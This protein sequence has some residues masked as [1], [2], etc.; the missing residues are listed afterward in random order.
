MN[1]I[2]ISIASY[3]DR[4]CPNTLI[5]L[6]ENAKNPENIIVGICQQNDSKKD[7][8][9][10][11]PKEH[12]LYSIIYKNIRKISIPHHLAKGPTYARF[13]CSTLHKDEDF[14]MQIDSHTYFIPNWDSILLEMFFQLENIGHQKVII[15]HYPPDIQDYKNPTKETNE[16]V[17]YMKSVNINQYGIP[18]FG[19]AYFK[20]PP[21][22]PEKNYY[23][24]CNF[25]IVRKQILKDVP[26][27]PYLPFLFEGEEILYSIRAYTS[28][29]NIFS[30]NK[31]ILYHFYI[32]K[33]EPKFWDD[34]SLKNKDSIL[35][36]K[37]YLGYPIDPKD[38]QSKEI[39]DSLSK[40]GLG[41]E[42]DIHS[43]WKQTKIP[44]KTTR[45]QPQ[46]L[47]LYFLLIII[48]FIICII[49]VLSFS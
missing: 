28:G 7:I 11:V 29:Y 26:F 47:L 34:L 40:Y 30:P 23:I 17:T 24:S 42:R 41:N 13:I 44:I 37:Y 5:N 2:F 25:Y 46:S 27:D 15:S 45:P 33:G 31:N 16:M 18:V 39:R 36:V 35:K 3:R 21:Q 32:R 6:Y 48:L 19:G 10:I 4:L 9:C 22:I 43:Y 14:F 1:K 20:Y 49:L 8:E 38:I 12:P